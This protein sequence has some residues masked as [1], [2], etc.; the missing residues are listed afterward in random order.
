MTGMSYLPGEYF[1]RYNPMRTLLLK[2]LLCCL[3]M[4]AVPTGWSYASDFIIKYY[5]YSMKTPA[6]RDKIV[7]F[8]KQFDGVNKVETVLERHW[9]Y[10]YLDDDILEDERFTIRV[11]LE[12]I[13]YPVDRWEVQLEKPNGQ[14]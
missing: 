12:K 10:I 8:I 14:D 4:T 11:P 9:V 6:D 7:S 2:I 3:L 1:M 13:G 5:I